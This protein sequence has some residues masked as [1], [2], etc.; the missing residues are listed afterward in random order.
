MT[1][2]IGRRKHFVPQVGLA[3]NFCITFVVTD[4]YK[5][6]PSH[7][8]PLTTAIFYNGR[9]CGLDIYGDPK[10]AGSRTYET[11]SHV[12]NDRIRTCSTGIL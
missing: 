8:P 4:P 7:E 10:Q 2:T 3:P 12:V 11:T 1:L 5:M 9:H 6:A